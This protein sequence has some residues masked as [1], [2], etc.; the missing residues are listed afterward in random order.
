MYTMDR[1]EAAGLVREINPSLVLPVHFG[2]D[3]IEGIAV[4]A[5]AFVVDGIRVERF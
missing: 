3:G 5:K 4:D 2:T 1:H